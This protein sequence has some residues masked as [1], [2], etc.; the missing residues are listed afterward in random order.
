MSP[1]LFR[2]L[3]AIPA[4]LCL[5]ALAAVSVDK[6]LNPTPAET[7]KME[8][9]PAE[10]RLRQSMLS[11]PKVQMTDAQVDRYILDLRDARSVPDVE[12]AGHNISGANTVGPDQSQ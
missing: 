3:I 12:E 1:V 10:N 4:V 9:T 6:Y 5:G 7:G 8:F 2:S 11:D